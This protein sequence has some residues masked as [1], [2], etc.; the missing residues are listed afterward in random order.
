MHPTLQPFTLRFRYACFPLTCKYDFLSPVAY[1]VQCTVYISESSVPFQKI[2]V[3][4]KFIIVPL[5][6][7]LPAA[8]TNLPL[9]EARMRFGSQLWL[10]TGNI[11]FNFQLY[12][13]QGAQSEGN[14]EFVMWGLSWSY[15]WVQSG[16]HY[17][18]LWLTR[19]VM[20][21]MRVKIH[22]ADQ[23]WEDPGDKQPVITL[24]LAEISNSL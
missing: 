18:L 3:C 16:S 20:E 6:M 7:S 12:N 14:L 22:T 23:A 24:G 13:N 5:G 8:R 17:V 19:G 4:W 1:S 9:N 15:N 21:R 11:R 10:Q 2:S